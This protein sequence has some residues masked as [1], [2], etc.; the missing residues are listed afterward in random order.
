MYTIQIKYN[1]FKDLAQN[2]FG[3]ILFGAK[4]ISKD[5]YH[6][7]VCPTGK[8]YLTL[9]LT[10]YNCKILGKRIDK[11]LESQLNQQYRSFMAKK[12]GTK[13]KADYKNHIQ[14]SRN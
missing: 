4:H 1:E 8:G 7:Q 6:L 13:W 12:F 2:R 3:M 14:L 10:D 5:V 11:D 9:E